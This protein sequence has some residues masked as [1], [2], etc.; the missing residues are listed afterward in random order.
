MRRLSSGSR[1]A[2]GSATARP[3]ATTWA[4]DAGR[5]W[6]YAGDVNVDGDL[7]DV[8]ECDDGD[9]DNGDGCDEACFTESGWSCSGTPSVCTPNCGNSA[10]D[11]GENCDDGLA[12]TGA[13]A[14]S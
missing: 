1:P 13:V 10:L 2:S 7:D 11:A 5:G 12:A 3:P 8:E 6:V 9:T 4:R 14:C